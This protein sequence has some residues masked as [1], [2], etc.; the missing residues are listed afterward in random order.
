M[1]FYENCGLQNLYDMVRYCQVEL[2][3]LTIVSLIF[4]TRDVS[5]E[6]IVIWM[7]YPV[8]SISSLKES[9]VEVLSFT[10]LTKLHKIAMVLFLF[11]SINSC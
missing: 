8:S 6:S 2:Y 11:C 7:C 1:V 4:M 5:N 3:M 10:I 9:A